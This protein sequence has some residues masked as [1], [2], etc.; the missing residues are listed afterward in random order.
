M[1][2]LTPASAGPRPSSEFVIGSF[3]FF[4][5]HAD[6][7]AWGC[8]LFIV[9][10]VGFATCTAFD[11]AEARASGNRKHEEIMHSTYF[12]GAF[13]YFVGTFFYFPTVAQR[14]DVLGGLSGERIGAVLFVGGSLAFIVAC[15]VNGSMANVHPGASAVAKSLVLLTTHSVLLGSCLFLV[16]SVLFL[17]DFKCE[18]ASV[19]FVTNFA[20]W[21]FV[22]GSA[23]F[24]VSAV[25]QVAVER[26]VRRGHGGL[27]LSGT[28]R[29]LADI[30]AEAIN[31]IQASVS[32]E[33]LELVDTQ[34]TQLQRKIHDEQ[35][36]RRWQLFAQHSSPHSADTGGSGA[37]AACAHSTA[38][39]DDGAPDGVPRAE[40][41][42]RVAQSVRLHSLGLIDQPGVTRPVDAGGRSLGATASFDDS[43]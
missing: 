43:W 26:T 1:P 40:V 9:G 15:F 25:L 12:I 36:K 11:Y 2:I 33:Q 7:V 28:Q 31:D 37:R 5:E 21:L 35:L 41:D 29:D 30:A 22:V 13:L 23:F 20:T 14:P 32:P 17:P 18:C 19:D 24:V 4:P 8:G 38:D 34:V 10:G 6:Q 3:F 27:D 16:G 39:G 42:A